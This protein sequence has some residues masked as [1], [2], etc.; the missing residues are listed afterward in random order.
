MK[1]E[2]IIF[3]EMPNRQRMENGTFFFFYLSKV[4]IKVS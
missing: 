1:K 3:P 2:R 4:S